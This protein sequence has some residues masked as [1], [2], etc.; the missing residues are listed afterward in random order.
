MKLD[1]RIVVLPLAVIGTAVAVSVLLLV[2]APAVV[3]VTPERSL[4]TVRVIEALPSSVRLQVRSQGT[5]APRTESELVPEL[6]G[7]VVWVSPSLVSGGFFEAGEPLLRID[8]RDYEATVQRARA[9]VSR[10]SGEA[11]H[12]DAQLSRRERLSKRDVASESQL[13]EAR[14]AALVARANL[15]DARV[16][17]EQAERDLTRT[18]LL[19][20]FSGRVREERVDVGQFASRGQPLASLYATDYAEIRLPIADHQLAYLSLPGLSG[21]EEEWGPEVALHARFAGADHT[22]HGRIVRTE[23]EIDARSRMVHVI[24]RV[25]DPYGSDATGRPPLAVGLFVN[26]EIEGTLAHDVLV[27]PRASLRD[28]DHLLVV[29]GEDRLRLRPARVLRVDREEVLVRAQL[30]PADRICVSN[31]PVAVDGMEVRPLAAP[32]TKWAEAPRP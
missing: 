24:A 27:A 20:P 3:S 31:L 19:A 16:A 17:L 2:T 32:T 12:A 6:S 10:A 11:E 4:T 14:R 18:E 21:A 1:R 25:E 7:P 26:A 5:V 29:D 28:D 8:A 23:G 13:S 22:W 9:A 15:T 30:A